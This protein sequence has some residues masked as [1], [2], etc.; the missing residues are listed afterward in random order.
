[1]LQ[2]VEYS[3]IKFLNWLSRWPDLLNVAH[4]KEL[5]LTKAARLLVGVT[6]MYWLAWIIFALH[7]W[8]VDYKNVSHIIV[9]VCGF[10]LAPFVAI[11]LLVL[12][13]LVADVLIIKPKERELIAKS[14]QIFANH[15][16]IKIAVAGSYGKTSMKEILTTLLSEKLKVAVTPGNMNT[17][18]AHARFAAKLNG[19]EDVLI[20][21]FGEGAPGDVERFAQTTHPDYAVITGLAPNHLDKYKTLDNLAADI[22]SLRR[23]VDREKLFIADNSEAIHKFIK[24][25]DQT[26]SDSVVGGWKIGNEKIEINGT[27]FTIQNTKDTLH[28]KSGILGRHMVASLAL[29]AVLGLKLGLSKSQVKHGL[30][31]TV[32]FEHRMQPFML[33]GAWVVDDT[34]NGNLE[35]IRAGLNLLKDLSAKRKIYVTPGLVDQGEE[36]EFVHKEIAKLIKQAKPDRVVLMDNSATSII[37]EQLQRAGYDGE[38]TLEHDPLNFYQNLEQYVAAGDLVVM[39]ND[40][41]DNY[42]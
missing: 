27:S 18:V 33:A 3:P 17:P 14:E 36:T 35:G 6:Y 41:T 32:A 8:L 30:S 28:I 5:V 10:L 23:F 19:D 31:K 29:V 7:Y 24:P 37:N 34:Y 16:A 22:F 39:Q 9:A 2:Q 21:E 4:R 40:W 26:Y 25:R 13:V 38:V 42:L 20:I 11:S 12:T 15:K 1:M